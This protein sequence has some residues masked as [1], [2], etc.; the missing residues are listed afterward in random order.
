MNRLVLI[1]AAVAASCVSTQPAPPPFEVATDLFVGTVR[2]GAVGSHAADEEAPPDTDA[3]PWMAHVRVAYVDDLP[4]WSGEPLSALA[5]HVFVER[6]DAPLKTRGELGL[7]VS[8]VDARAGLPV[9]SGDVRRT[10]ALW[11]GTTAI[12]SATPNAAAKRPP[13]PAWER[14]DV[15]LARARGPGGGTELALVFDGLVTPREEAPIDLGETDDTPPPPAPEP[16]SQR[17]HVVL[18][19]AP[20]PGA[21]PFRFLLPAPRAWLR[22]DPLVV[23]KKQG[24][25]VVEVSVLAADVAVDDEAVERGLAALSRSRTLVGERARSFAETEGFRYESQT[26]LNALQLERLQR[27][28]LVFLAQETGAALTSELALLADEDTLAAYLS[29]LRER[30][31]QTPIENE[32]PA[33]GW[34]LESTAYVWIARIAEDPEQA[35]APELDALLLVHSGELGR[36][37]DLVLETVA[38]C[39]N[40]DSFAVKL[41]EENRIFLEDGNP[42]ARV[43]SFDWLQLRDA[44]PAGYDPL[45]TIHA[46]RAA[47]SLAE[48]SVDAEEGTE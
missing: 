38:G 16:V 12:W 3:R 20:A 48:T 37:P 46:R 42:S 29:A 26:A 36:Y 45:D 11:P 17:E 21:E 40:L 43:R 10:E 7:G 28:A 31:D 33:L 1:T 34:F 35:L 18:V 27:S 30:L 23:R 4:D 2:T 22:D 41:V 32:R 19:E 5:R 6:S 14:L 47:L 9:P 15:Q 39:G 13:A 8:R 25:F 44:D 24:G